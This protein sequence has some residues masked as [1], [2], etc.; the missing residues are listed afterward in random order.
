MSNN[1][2][3]ASLLD[4]VAS[5]QQAVF[6]RYFGAADAAVEAKR[7]EGVLQAAILELLD[8]GGCHNDE[9]CPPGYY[10]DLKS[11]VCRR[12]PTNTLKGR[13]TEDAYR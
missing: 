11:E 6:H 2:H 5:L 10:C 9:D 4:E 13:F 3:I 12:D 7:L 8:G 1:Q